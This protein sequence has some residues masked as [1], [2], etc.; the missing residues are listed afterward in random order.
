[1]KD[2]ESA[3]SFAVALAKERGLQEVTAD[4]LLL[5]CLRAISQFGIVQLGDW[6]IDLEALGV[7]WLSRPEQNGLKV[8]YSQTVVNIFDLAARIARSDESGIH[9]EHLLVAF[10]AEDTGLM[11]ELK[12][13]HGITS[14]GWRAAIARLPLRR[15]DGRAKE[16]RDGSS[17]TEIVRDYLSPEEAADGLGVHVQT[18]RAYV[19]SG[20]LPA[21]RLAGERAIRIRRADLDKLLEPVLPETETR[22]G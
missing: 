7:D 11:S 16:S 2:T 20:K 21:L 12:R 3:A 22:G 14:G 9:V 1:M 4:E 5:G 6:T 18:L 17:R 8:V 19:R 13:T 10:A 15:A